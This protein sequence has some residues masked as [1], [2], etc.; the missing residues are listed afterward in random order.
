MVEDKG[1]EVQWVWSDEVAAEKNIIYV[2][3]DFKTTLYNQLSGKA[4]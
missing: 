2:L 1:V 3:Q 4:R